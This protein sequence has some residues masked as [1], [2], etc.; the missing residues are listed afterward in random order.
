MG[1][2]NR[3]AKDRRGHDAG[4]RGTGLFVERSVNPV[5]VVAAGV[6]PAQRR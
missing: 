3:F 6:S 5:P 4:T 1:C 2:S